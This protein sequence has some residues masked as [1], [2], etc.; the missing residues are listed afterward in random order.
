[1]LASP[2]VTSLF[3]RCGGEQ[4]QR[5]AMDPGWTHKSITYRVRSRVGW[6][7][8]SNGLAGK[9]HD[10]E[11]KKKYRE[12]FA[13]RREQE[14]DLPIYSTFGFPPSRIS[15]FPDSLSPHIRPIIQPA[16]SSRLP[17]ARG[18]HEATAQASRCGSRSHRTMETGRSDTSYRGRDARRHN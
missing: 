2:L 9:V 6:I 14:Y 7:L 5:P 15:P 4:E 11:R 16:Y 17:P 1:M 8:Q 3:G 12:L 13:A 10:T 18:R